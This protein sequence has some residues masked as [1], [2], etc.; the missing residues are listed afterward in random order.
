MSVGVFVGLTVGVTDGMSVGGMSVGTTG[1][2]TGV[3]TVGSTVGVTVDMGIL[4][5]G[6]LI[7]NATEIVIAIN[8][9]ITIIFFQLSRNQSIQLR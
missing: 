5:I 9:I 6:N 4:S 2:L 3:M 7:A 8:E 1:G